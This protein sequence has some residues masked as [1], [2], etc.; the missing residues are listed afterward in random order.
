MGGLALVSQIPTSAS[1]SSFASGHNYVLDCD[2]QQSKEMHAE[3][4][5]KDT[6]QIILPHMIELFPDTRSS[7]PFLNC[8]SLATGSY[9]GLEYEV[10]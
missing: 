7:S 5:P 3:E 6:E 10:V 2:Y 1:V 9:P 8:I 4:T